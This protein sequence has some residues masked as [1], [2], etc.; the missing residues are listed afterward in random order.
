MALSLT[1][2]LAYIS[3]WPT[4]ATRTGFVPSANRYQ[5]ASRVVLLYVSHFWTQG[6]W[7]HFASGGV[8]A[9]QHVS[10][11]LCVRDVPR[12]GQSQ[13]SS[14]IDRVLHSYSSSGS[15]CVE[16]RQ[17][18]TM[19]LTDV[20]RLRKCVTPAPWECNSQISCSPG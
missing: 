16:S 5:C 17:R 1:S 4:T 13:D 19:I 3:S 7:V 11:D 14:N 10:N 15:T 8:L 2:L 12:S 9:G 18:T 20:M 6:L